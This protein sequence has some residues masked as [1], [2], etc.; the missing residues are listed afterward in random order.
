MDGTV[1]RLT[2]AICSPAGYATFCNVFPPLLSPSLPGLR[3][4]GATKRYSCAGGWRENIYEIPFGLYFQIM[5]G[6]SFRRRQ[7][8]SWLWGK[9]DYVIRI[10]EFLAAP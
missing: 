1:P 3:P 9:I 6:V 5:F 4:A 7:L 2:V 8:G 10:A